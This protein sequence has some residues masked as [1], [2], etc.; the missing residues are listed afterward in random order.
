MDIT[1]TF[2][3]TIKDFK[4][5][6]VEN[7]P[8]VN[9]LYKDESQKL[10]S[11][12][13]IF[14]YYSRS[15]DSTE[16][17]I[18]KAW[19]ENQKTNRPQFEE[20]IRIFIGEEKHLSLSDHPILYFYFENI[21][22][23]AVKVLEDCNFLFK[24]MSLGVMEKSTRFINFDTEEA[25][26]PFHNRLLT[27]IPKLKEK[28]DEIFNYR[29]DVYKEK[30]KIYKEMIEKINEKI[31]EKINGKMVLDSTRYELPYGVKTTCGISMNAR[32]AKRKIIELLSSKIDECK[33]IGVQMLEMV[34]KE[35]PYM[36]NEEE[37]KNEVLAN[38]KFNHLQVQRLIQA[39]ISK[40]Y[41]Y[42]NE[43]GTGISD[44]KQLFVLFQKFFDKE[45]WKDYIEDIEHLYNYG[46][47]MSSKHIIEDYENKI[48]E[49][50]EDIQKTKRQ[51][52]NVE[53]EKA[54]ENLDIVSSNV[55]QCDIEGDI[56]SFR[57]IH[58]NRGVAVVFDSTLDLKIDTY[59][60][61]IIYPRFF[62]SPIS[63]SLMINSIYTNPWDEY[64]ERKFRS[65]LSE[66]VDIYFEE[67]IKKFNFD[68]EQFNDD[69]DLSN[70]Y[71]FVYEKW[72]EFK[73]LLSY[74]FP[75]GTLKEYRIYGTLSS[76]IQLVNNRTGK[77]G[78]SAYKTIAKDIGRE[79]KYDVREN[80]ILDYDFL[81]TKNSYGDI[82]YKEDV[83][84]E[85]VD[86]ARDYIIEKCNKE[87]KDFDISEE[88]GE[89]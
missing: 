41:T 29:M 62:R 35:F 19:K 20:F 45:F 37:I 81:F 8:I 60:E 23:V 5:H 10:M 68:K 67:I 18:E 12:S 77:D 1:S 43:I 28:F 52:P 9:L 4:N 49:I 55:F 79:L 27:T 39:T 40:N 56:G 64:F 15:H 44:A 78:H 69:N 50:L 65:L 70:Y 21:S 71:L 54:Y 26:K 34:T 30:T 82:Q 17:L 66:F 53:L 58:R 11:V 73:E 89:E 57:D 63:Y 59:E 75:M 3:D 48:I 31:G 25:R 32:T 72:N 16:K 61:K 87:Y 74:L 7:P 33:Y 36:F 46:N 22:N 83:L 47:A 76:I 6:Q 80:L 51:F 14:G 84:E 88:G 24:H 85:Y 42:E 86:I 13:A 2:Y 38:V